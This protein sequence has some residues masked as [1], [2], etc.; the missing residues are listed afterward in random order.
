[1]FEGNLYNE[2]QPIYPKE[3]IMII[4]KKQV[5][6]TRKGHNHRLQTNP[7]YDEEETQNTD[8][9]QINYCRWNTTMDKPIH[10][11]EHNDCQQLITK[12]RDQ[13]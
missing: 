8:A 3:Q 13:S 7:W 2:Q 4:S 11:R 1:M 6:M 10:E 9:P 12:S 5:S